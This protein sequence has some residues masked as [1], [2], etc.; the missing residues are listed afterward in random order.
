M[1][2]HAARI[3]LIGITTLALAA[4]G[5]AFSAGPVERV[6]YLRELVR[7]RMISGDTV[8]IDGCSTDR[9]MEGVPAW[10][11]S[12]LTAE[13]SIIADTS[14]C[15][16]ADDSVRTVRGRFVLT[17]WY[18]NWSGEYVIRGA[19]VAFDQ[20]YRF[21]DG[22]FVGH[23]KIEG[24]RYSTGIAPPAAARPD[25]ARVDSLT[26][27]SARAA[28]PPGDTAIDTRPDSARPGP[29]GSRRR[30]SGRPGQRPGDA[31]DGRAAGSSARTD[32]RD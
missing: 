28:G 16:S 15:P 3:A 22:V 12:L 13:R 1:P 24:E 18:R 14:P 4:C 23:E 10:R 21:S 11:D 29:A 5:R 32:R 31:K 27:D 19:T 2:T 30:T 7:V 26:R 17:S 25:S 8:P 20:G 6:G 9:F